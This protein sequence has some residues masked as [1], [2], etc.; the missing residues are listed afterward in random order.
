MHVEGKGKVG[1]L[2]INSQNMPRGGN[3]QPLIFSSLLSCR[4]PDF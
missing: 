3:G 1:I 2:K 4:N